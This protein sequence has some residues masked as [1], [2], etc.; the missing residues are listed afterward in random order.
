MCV[1]VCVCLLPFCPRCDG[2]CVYLF[3]VGFDLVSGLVALAIAIKSGSHKHNCS[4][5]LLLSV[6]ASVSVCVLVCHCVCVPV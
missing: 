4:H 2:V 6:C 1:S 5:V 3:A